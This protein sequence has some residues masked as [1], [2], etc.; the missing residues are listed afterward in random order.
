V[1]SFDE[2]FGPSDWIMTTTI[3]ACFDESGKFKDQRVIVFGGVASNAEYLRTD[4]YS[5]WARALRN[6]GLNF[7]TMKEALK[8]HRNLSDK[9][10]ALGP[11]KRIEA[12]LPFVHCIRKNLQIMRCFSVNAEAF[13]KLPQ[14]YRE[15]LF[16][17][18]VYLAFLL[19]VIKVI[20]DM[21]GDGII[22]FICDDEEQTALPMYD[23]Y[24][25]IKRLR[26]E[27]RSKMRGISFVDDEWVF[28]V[29]AA[30]FV[31][32]LSRL[33]ATRKFHGTNYDYETLF[34]ALTKD[35]ESHEKIWD[36]DVAFC[37][38]DNLRALAI[39][40]LQAEKDHKEKIA[41]EA[42]G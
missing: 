39:E 27:F 18:P 20:D 14:H 35:P 2:Y 11:D 9:N 42:K 17:D 8:H 12:L 23:L 41:N 5:D 24:R 21:P 31:T 40:A 3:N 28:G 13:R 38:E 10:P 25:K 7:L 16:N 6:N 29:Q 1:Q 22:S 19:T 30:D 33:E 4:F 36:T 32:S 15:A 37:D 34:A 26:P